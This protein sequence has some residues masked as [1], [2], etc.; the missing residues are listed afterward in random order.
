MLTMIVPRY[1]KNAVQH[2]LEEKMVFISGPRQVGKTTLAKA[3]LTGKQDL[4]FNWDRR[5]DRKRILSGRW[6]AVKST[7]VLDELHKYSR[8]KQWIKGE[9]DTHADRIRF[10]ITGVKWGT[11]V[12][13]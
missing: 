1:L 5:E 13:K 4:Y 7:V 11:S 2:D 12:N 10:L 8:W 6:P 3:F 9:Y